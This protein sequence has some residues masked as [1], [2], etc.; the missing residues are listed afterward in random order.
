[1]VFGHSSTQG[2]KTKPKIRSKFANSSFIDELIRNRWD[3]V[4]REKKLLPEL[5][6][7]CLALD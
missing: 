4:Y 2:D 6:D 1:M 3:R 5:A 7:Q